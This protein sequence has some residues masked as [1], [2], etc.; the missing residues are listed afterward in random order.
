MLYYKLFWL[1]INIDW[2]HKNNIVAQPFKRLLQ[3]TSSYCKKKQR[4]LIKVATFWNNNKKD[5]FSQETGLVFVHGEVFK[6]GSRI[7]ATFKIK[8]FT[9]IR[10]SRKLQ[11]ASSDMQQGSWICPWFLCFSSFYAKNVNTQYKYEEQ[12]NL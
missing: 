4:I 1:W 8:L 3:R 6:E 7:S 12:T 5:W 10:N 2:T 9:A 11:M